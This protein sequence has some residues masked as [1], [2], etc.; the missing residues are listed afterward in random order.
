MN[1]LRIIIFH[2]VHY[3]AHTG[4]G[5]T[6]ADQII[7]FSALQFICKKIFGEFEVVE[8]EPVAVVDEPEPEQPLPDLADLQLISV[9]ITPVQQQAWFREG[10]TDALL[11]LAAGDTFREWTLHRVEPSYVMFRAR[12]SEYRVDLRPVG[13]VVNSDPAGGRVAPR[14]RRW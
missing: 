12:D 5:A 14:S 8:E 7:C 11:R 2:L 1:D 9:V 10:R 4:D 6:D 13:A 3:G